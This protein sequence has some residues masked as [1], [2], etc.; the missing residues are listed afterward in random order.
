MDTTQL[1][2]KEL[3][4]VIFRATS[5]I[6]IAGR[7]IEVGEPIA[8]FE[9]IQ[10]GEYEEMKNYITAHGG[11]HDQTRIIWEEPKQMTF[12]FT[13]GVFSY[14]HLAFLGNS[15]FVSMQEVTVPKIEDLE[16]D[17]Q[18]EVE[19][20]YE[21]ILSSLFIYDK[22]GDK[23]SNFT[24]ND[25]KI[26]FPSLLPFSTVRVMYNFNYTNGAQRL[27]VGR[28]LLTGFI[29]VIGKT[30]L[31]DDKTG[32]ATTGVLS[33]PRVKLMNDLSIILGGSVSPVVGNFQAVGYPTGARGREKVMEITLL[34]DDID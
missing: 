32:I 20:K 23:I 13:Q 14:L 11:Y 19:L 16:I 26:T 8:V 17:D 22:K 21:P 28:S 2:L 1:G 7:A 31:V 24:I 15:D 30:R 9:R 25:K 6:E 29:E 3:Y 27:H 10:Y 18:L 5:K 12:N 33:I 4:E 34:N